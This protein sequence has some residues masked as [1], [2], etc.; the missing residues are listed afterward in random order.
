MGPKEEKQKLLR[1]E[2]RIDKKTL[3]ILEKQFH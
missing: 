3:K 2:N 1:F